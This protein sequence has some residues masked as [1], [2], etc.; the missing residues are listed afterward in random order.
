MP[1]ISTLP[2]SIVSGAALG[3]TWYQQMTASTTSPRPRSRSFSFFDQWDRETNISIAGSSAKSELGQ[4]GRV[5][6]T[7][8]VGSA[9]SVNEVV[10][11]NGLTRVQRTDSSPLD[12]VAETRRDIFVD[13]FWI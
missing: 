13:T 1:V 7:P 3:V 12:A 5:Q 9:N 11:K 2:I 8:V 10:E 6:S 4:L